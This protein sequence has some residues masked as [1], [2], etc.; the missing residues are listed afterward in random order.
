MKTFTL[1]KNTHKLELPAEFQHDDVRYS[2]S[3][4][5]YLLEEFTQKGN[6]VFDPFAGF[7]TTLRVAEEMGRVPFGIEFDP[8][9][10]EYARSQLAHPENLIHGDSR[11][12]L[13]YDVPP[14]D[15]SLT[16]PP[17]MGKRDRDNP[18]TAYTTPN[19]GYPAYLQDIQNIY[20]QMRDLMKPGARVVIEAANLKQW[21]GLTT[22]AWDIAKAVSEVLWF[23]GEI[24]IGWDRYGYGYDHSYCLVFSN[25]QGMDLELAIASSCTEKGCQ[26]QFVDSGVQVNADYAELF[27]EHRIAVNPG[28]LAVVDRGTNPPQVVYRLPLAQ[29]ERLE[30]ENILVHAV[31]GHFKPQT[32]VH[33]LETNVALG[34]YVFIAFGQVHDVSIDG[35]PANPERLRA[36]FFPMIQALYQQQDAWKDLNPKQIV[37]EGYDDIAERHHKWA[38]TTRSEERER[39]TSVLLDELPPGAEVLDLGCGAGVPTTHELAQR[40]KV[41]GV[42][43]SARQ[44]ELARQNVP[45]AQFIQ[46]DIT[47]LDF[48]P[49]SF[50][51][52]VAFYSIIHVPREEQLKLLQDIASWLRPGGLLVAAMGTHSAKVDFDEDFL[53]A[54][55]YWSG[56]DGETNKRM[57]EEAGL[58]IISAQE[59][60][61]PEF[62]Q[63]VTF[64]WIVAQKSTLEDRD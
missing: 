36:V 40:F 27:I 37:Q 43:I 50:D 34:D 55:M 49:A 38:Q 54:P 61:V 8:Q 26:V 19:H 63:M 32:P 60:T 58:R 33:G 12:L 45:D 30:D 24:V 7:G 2:E 51:A 29:V 18:L 64:L 16:S 48:A 23:E 56:F 3:L 44:I 28:D 17:Y 10:A 13:S 46:A 41:T 9:R 1:F 4:V 11:Q 57:V 6:V 62:D 35:R 53:G 22:L 42:D 15:F 31:C 39:Y 20:A 47:Q 59:E 5:K 25:P 14:F 52:I 21:D